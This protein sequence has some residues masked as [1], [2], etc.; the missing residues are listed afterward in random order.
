MKSVFHTIGLCSLL[1]LVGCDSN[2]PVGSLELVIK[3][4]YQGA[5]LVLGQNY[6]YFDGSNILLTRS[7][8]FLSDIKLSKGTEHHLLSDVEYAA[9]LEHHTSAAKAKEGYVLKKFDNIPTGHYKALEFG[10]GLNAQ[11]NKTSPKDYNANHPLGEGSRYWSAWHSY[12]F[13]KT[14]GVYET[15]NEQINFS[16]HSGFDNSFRRIALKRDI[17]ITENTTTRIIIELDHH[18][19]FGQN[20]NYFDIKASPQIHN[21]SVLIEKLMD[22]FAQSFHIQ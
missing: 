14:E 1:V 12:V 21:R 19:V 22:W 2:T 15:G 4:T 5:P 9:L 11:Q 8:F 13:S 6:T 3:G 17:T 20:G 18:L 7:D 16:Y 10:L